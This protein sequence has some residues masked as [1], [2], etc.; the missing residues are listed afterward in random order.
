MNNKPL[1]FKELTDRLQ[2]ALNA[3]PEIADK[4]VIFIDWN[5][6]TTAFTEGIHDNIVDSDGNVEC[7]VLG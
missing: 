1:T 7:V 6:M 2:Y 4:P 5:D 3:M